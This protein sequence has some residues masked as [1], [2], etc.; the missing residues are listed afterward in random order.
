[1]SN[2]CNER[3]LIIQK[4][5]IEIGLKNDDNIEKLIKFVNDKLC[6]NKV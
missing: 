2:A 1:M 3:V 6:W 5:N 4:E